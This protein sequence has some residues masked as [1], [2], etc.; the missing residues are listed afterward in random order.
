MNDVYRKFAA[1]VSNAVG[2]FWALLALLALVLGTGS[3]FDFSPAWKTNTSLIAAVTALIV[4][5][6]LQHSQNHSDKAAHLKLDELIRASKRARDDTAS[7][8][9]EPESRIKELKK[10]QRADS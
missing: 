4:L 10:D 8:E 7:V 3:Y 5:C 9:E 2:S 6:F 1:A